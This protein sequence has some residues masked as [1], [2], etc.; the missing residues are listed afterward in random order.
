MIN[1]LDDHFE[2][3][4]S[5]ILDY[6][7][8]NSSH[9][10]DRRIIKA[11]KIYSIDD[12]DESPRYRQ[13]KAL[14][15][16]I[17]ESEE[18]YDLKWLSALLLDLISENFQEVADTLHK[19]QYNILPDEIVDKLD[20]LRRV[21][22]LVYLYDGDKILDALEHLMQH[23][24][25]DSISTAEILWEQYHYYDSEEVDY[26]LLIAMANIIIKKLSTEYSTYFFLGY[27]FVEQELFPQALNSYIKA[28]EI[29]QS[30]PALYEQIS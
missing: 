10:T 13:I 6:L 8:K 19:L 27:I 23:P 1:I 11:L 18:R 9:F 25:S 17:L 22:R 30:D 16:Q 7:S 20:L 26:D 3:V 24:A 21:A 15:P 4:K 29:C 2:T 28:L 14:R 5:D 12:S